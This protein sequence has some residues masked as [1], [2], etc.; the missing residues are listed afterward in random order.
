MN[1]EIPRKCVGRPTKVRWN[2]YTG[3]VTK[4]KASGT[5]HGYWDDVPGKYRF[6]RNF[7]VG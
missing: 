7:W 3:R 5:M 6:V 2:V 4:Y 1:F